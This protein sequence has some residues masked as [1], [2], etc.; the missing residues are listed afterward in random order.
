MQDPYS[1]RC[2][3]QV[4]GASRD[5][6]RHTA[7]VVEDEL[8]AVTDN[9]LIFDDGTVISGGLFHGQPLALVLDYIA[10]ALAELASIS[11]RR[12]YLL[13]SGTAQLPPFLMEQIGVNSGFMVAQYVAAA[14]VSEN[15]GLCS[16]ASVDSIPTSMGQEDHVSMGATSANKLMTILENAETV[17]AIE[18]L[19]AAQA[20]DFRAPLKPG[21]GPQ[22]AHRKAR[23]RFEFVRSDRVLAEELSSAVEMIRLQELTS[24]VASVIEGFR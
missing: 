7:G 3:P 4:H 1:I 23:E 18:M 2:V 5:A 22:A 8:N 16:P 13:L 12:S 24:S 15:K 6:I 10:I 11:E 19:C 20:L 21:A 9:P 14:L 17:L